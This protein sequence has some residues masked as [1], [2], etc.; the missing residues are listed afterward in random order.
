MLLK[1]GVAQAFRQWQWN[2]KPVM[3]QAWSLL[4]TVSLYDSQCSS[5]ILVSTSSRRASLLSVGEC[6]KQRLSPRQ[7]S[8]LLLCHCEV[9]NKETGEAKDKKD[10]ANPMVNIPQS[11]ARA[12]IGQYCLKDHLQNSLDTAK[13]KQDWLCQG[14]W[15]SPS[16]PLH[17]NQTLNRWLR[18]SLE[19]I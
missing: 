16:F 15:A 12:T 8:L 19:S 13:G 6:R 7:M 1:S 4:Q 9:G 18:L 5:S 3:L 14:H 17:F 11:G 2:P 10:H